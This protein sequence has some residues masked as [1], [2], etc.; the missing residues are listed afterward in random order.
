M[1]ERRNT[2]AILVKDLKRVVNQP[3]LRLQAAALPLISGLVE[4]LLERVDILLVDMRGDGGLLAV[5]LLEG[6]PGPAHEK[7]EEE[8]VRFCKRTT[9]Q[10]AQMNVPC[11]GG[12]QACTLTLPS[13]G[14]SS[15][16]NQSMPRGPH[17]S[18]TTPVQ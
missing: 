12:V 6:R 16:L 7:K 9:A 17:S 15:R 14:Q 13:F 2:A 11:E 8:R 18:S 5:R 1:R 4:D 3:L 10:Q